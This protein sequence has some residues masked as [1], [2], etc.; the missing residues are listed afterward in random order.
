MSEDKL[1]RMFDKISDI[2]ERI[3]RVEVLIKE[4]ADDTNDTKTTLRRHEE[5]IAELESHKDSFIGA[6]DIVVWLAITGIALWEVL[7]R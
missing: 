2:S 5:R 1:D 3:V 4:V 6:K 7:S